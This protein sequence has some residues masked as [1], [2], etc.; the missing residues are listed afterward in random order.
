MSAA[1][2]VRKYLDLLSGKKFTLRESSGSQLIYTT[3]DPIFED[4]DSYPHEVQNFFDNYITTWFSGNE[5]IMLHTTLDNFIESTR[6]SIAFLRSLNDSNADHLSNAYTNILDKVNVL[7]ANLSSTRWED[8]VQKSEV[9]RILP[10]LTDLGDWDWITVHNVVDA[11]IENELNT[12][13]DSQIV[14]VGNTIKA[15]YSAY[16]EA[17][18]AEAQWEREFNRFMADKEGYPRGPRG[19]SESQRRHN[20]KSLLENASF[21][22]LRSHWNASDAILLAEVISEALHGDLDGWTEEEKRVINDFL[23]DLADTCANAEELGFIRS[24]GDDLVESGSTQWVVTFS[25]DD[26]HYSTDSEGEILDDTISRLVSASSKQEAIKKAKKY[27]RNKSVKVI[28]V[29]KV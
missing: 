22:L 28:N 16:K 21:P 20:K 3:W 18:S 7:K 8:E 10:A 15:Q 26:Y 11:I 27:Y 5:P 25:V 4:Y 9:L 29:R 19:F 14:S 12:V 6:E 24:S 23:D 2:E 1:K 17:D 13:P